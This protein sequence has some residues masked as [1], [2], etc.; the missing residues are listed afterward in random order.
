MK[1]ALES[2]GSIADNM[3]R[4]ISICSREPRA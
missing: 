1:L 2:T 4:Y 3:I